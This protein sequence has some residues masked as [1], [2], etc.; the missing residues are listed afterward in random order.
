MNTS[1]ISPNQHH[2][3]CRL[4]V[5]PLTRTRPGLVHARPVQAG[6]LAPDLDHTPTL[7]LRPAAAVAD[8]PTHDLSPDQPGEEATLTHLPAP[9]PLH[10]NLAPAAPSRTADPRADPCHEQPLDAAVLDRTT[11][12]GI[13][14]ARHLAHL[15][16]RRDEGNAGTGVTPVRCLGPLRL[17]DN[18][19]GAQHLKEDV[20]RRVSRRLLVVVVVV[21]MILAHLLHRVVVRAGEDIRTRCRGLLRRRVGVADRLRPDRG[22]LV[23]LITFNGIVHE[24]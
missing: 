3:R 1:R 5:R 15:H 20:T 9:G 16:H 7:V 11:P 10:Q 23:R 24:W 12:V 19:N 6:T 17:L 18:N 21:E 2:Q 8:G 22:G 4:L 13:T 14:P